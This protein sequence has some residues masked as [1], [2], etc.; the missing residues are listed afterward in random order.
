MRP[1]LLGTDCP[2]KLQASC[3]KQAVDWKED[4]CGDRHDLTEQYLVAHASSGPS[5][6]QI[7]FRVLLMKRQTRA[8]A[9]CRLATPRGRGLWVATANGLA[10]P[11]KCREVTMSFATITV[12]YRC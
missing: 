8:S 11:Q 1:C 12:T 5:G 2:R 6:T 3:P 4:Q 10:E 9:F 7:H